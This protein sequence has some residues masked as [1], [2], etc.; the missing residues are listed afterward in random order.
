MKEKKY[1]FVYKTTNKKNK[2]IYI[3]VHSTNSLKDS[4]LGSGKALKNAI[5]KYGIENFKRGREKTYWKGKTEQS[6]SN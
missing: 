2:K 5:N 1:I 3:G 6:C 4:Y